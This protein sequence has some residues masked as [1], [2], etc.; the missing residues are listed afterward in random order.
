ML[1]RLFVVDSVTLTSTGTAVSSY[2]PWD[3]TTRK[4][5]TQV[6]V[7]ATGQ[8]A[9]VR[10]SNDN[11]AATNA[12]VL[13]QG[14]DHVVLSV[15]GRRWVS[16]LSDGASS[17]VNVGALSTGVSGSAASLDLAFVDAGVLDP[18]V[19]FTRTGTNATYFNSAGVLTS[20]GADVP[21][22]DY[23]PSTLAAQGLLIEEQRTNSIRNNTMQGAVAGTPGT[24]PTNWTIG[25]VTTGLTIS[26]VGT[27]T[28]SG[29]TYIDIRFNGTAGAALN[30]NI[31]FDTSTGIA[32]ANG[33]T[34]A[35]SSYVSLVGGSLTNVTGIIAVQSMFSSVPTLLGT[36]SGSP[37]VP[38]GAA[39]NTQR[40]TFVGTLNQATTAFVRPQLQFSVANGAAIDITLRIG[41]PQLE[42]GAF[43]TSV[44]PTTTTALTRNA[45]VASVNTLSPWFNATSGTLFAQGILVGGTAGNFPFQATLAGSNPNTDAIGINWGAASTQMRGVI[46]VS[47]VNTMD[48]PAGPAKVAGNSFRSAVTYQLNNSNFATDGTVASDDTAV[49]L[50]TVQS[51]LIGQSAVFQS[52]AS[53]WIQRITYYPRRLS[54]AELQAITA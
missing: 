53:V 20:A 6:V 27:G 18:R 16:V 34:W 10:L 47:N 4:L 50:P 52:T 3:Q 2:T 45:D 23:N 14:G 37:F 38:T 1:N 19:T 54:N 35:W 15:Q 32:A 48:L 40:Q 22:L 13:V 8:G 41:M 33:Q 25:G 42:L 26:V 24:L 12:D 44:I 31:L 51:L 36:L 43:A 7:K 30:P 9:Y 28:E 46:R 21:R 49:T 11:S 17:T 5:P 39:L 29:I